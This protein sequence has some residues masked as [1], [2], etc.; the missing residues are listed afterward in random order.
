MHVHAL[1][2][3]LNVSDFGA[4]VAW[5]SRFGWSAGFSWCPP[6]STSPT[7]G[8]VSAGPCEIFLCEGAQG[9]RGEDGVWMSIWVSDVDAVYALCEPSDMAMPPTDEPW[10]VR[11]MHLRHPDGHTF[12]ISAT[13]PTNTITSTRTS[14]SRS[15]PRGYASSW[16]TVGIS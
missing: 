3:I 12:R 8:S 11:E 4:S 6:G 14:T 2:P 5:F 7:F 9:G 15:S 13:P 16:R 10:G 1:T